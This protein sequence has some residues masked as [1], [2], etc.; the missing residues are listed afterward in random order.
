[1]YATMSD[2]NVTAY[3]KNLFIFLNWLTM[4]NFSLIPTVFPQFFTWIS[5]DD[6]GLSFSLMLERKAITVEEKLHE[7]RDFIINI[8]NPHA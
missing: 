5:L 1:M 3:G 7:L 4:S 8:I 2:S 6:A